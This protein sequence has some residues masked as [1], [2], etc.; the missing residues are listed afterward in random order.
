[1]SFGISVPNP[2]HTT[3]NPESR[4]GAPPAPH[5]GFSMS[6]FEPISGIIGAGAGLISTHLQN[7]AQKALAQ[8]QMDF[9]ERM[10]STAFQRAKTDM[11]L[12]GINPAL[13]AGGSP[14]ASSPQGAQAQL[15]NPLEAVSALS[16]AR[17]ARAQARLLELEIPGAE[18]ESW[19]QQRFGKL[20]Q[21]ASG[22]TGILGRLIFSGRSAASARSSWHYGT[23]QKNLNKR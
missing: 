11:E 2:F 5:S 14:S 17:L 23:W 22:L 7:K 12:A 18:A 15:R 1:M 19:Y 3:Q 4:F 16:H 13:L 9:Q 10:S 6:S 20:S 21:V 8:K